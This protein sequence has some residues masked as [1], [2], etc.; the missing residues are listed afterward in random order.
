M[1][2]LPLFWL[3]VALLFGILISAY[4]KRSGLFWS[5]LAGVSL[6][7]LVG[8]VV[9]RKRIKSTLD[10]GKWLPVPISLLCLALF[11]GA[12]RYQTNLPHFSEKNLGY[13][14]DQG[15]MTVEGVV[16]SDPQNLERSSRFV[17]QAEFR[18]TSH[19]EKEPLNGKML[20]QYRLGEF[21]YGDRL[22]LTG[23]LVTPPE[24]EE[25]SYRDYLARSRVYSLMA[26]PRLKLLSENQANSIQQGL[27]AFRQFVHLK[28]Q[29]FL[30]QPEAAL[31]SGILLGIE[32]DIPNDLELAFQNTGTAHIIAIS[33][34]NMTLLAALFLK[35]FRR[36]LPVWWAGALAVLAITVYTLF[37]GAAPAVQRAA[38]M[39]SLSMTGGLIGRKQAGPFTLLLTVAVMVFFN[40]LFLWDA[41]FQLSVMA[42]LGLI[43]YA[44][45]ILH[46]F[47]NRMRRWVSEDKVKQ[48]SGPVGEYFLFTLAAQLTIFPVLLYHFESFSLSSFIA[49]PLILPPQP[50]VMMFGGIAVLV[51][52]VVPFL[53]RYLSYVVW[54]P[55][56]YTNRMVTWLSDFSLGTLQFGEINWIVVLILY[57][58]IFGLTLKSSF[59][60]WLFS[61]WQ[62]AL[63]TVLS[64]GCAFLVWNIVLHQPD[65]QLKIEVFGQPHQQGILVETPSGNTL[66]INPGEYGNSMSSSI[67]EF[68]SVFDRS[69]DVVMITSDKQQDYAALP[70]LLKRFQVKQLLW[71]AGFPDTFLAEE[72]DQTAFLLNIPS[73]LF[74][75]GM[76]LDCGDGVLVEMLL[77]QE[78]QT[79]MQ[80]GYKNFRMLVIQGNISD[81]VLEKWPP[82]AVVYLNQPVEVMDWLPIEASLVIVPESAPQQ[83][84]L[85][86][87]LGL[88]T[89]N[90]LEIVSDGE[91]LSLFKY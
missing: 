15:V 42:T 54:I 57:V 65:G 79:V 40:P 48:I 43:L 60:S 78:D 49:N 62:P 26:F 7:C 30:P 14:N 73:D 23:D 55:L 27:Y 19:G 4:L 52:L 68:H 51:G 24:N 69:L 72:I 81:S 76:V 17:F 8:E 11:V 56:V 3:S 38:V 58:L 29:Q 31:L 25:F 28:I 53:G 21:S 67:T 34:F 64:V 86:F 35:G 44:D 89:V 91:T 36:W 61:R 5:F 47:Q 80:I 74:S 90:G 33:G 71:A 39:S 32:T 63:T 12:W 88:N 6:V 83:E 84:S 46:W 20:V 50:F 77:A 13:Y 18:H 2:R 59:R 75:E 1:R 70:L 9:L 22:L 82:A 66:L 45:K 16:V 10:K 41:G 37:V 85:D 87:V